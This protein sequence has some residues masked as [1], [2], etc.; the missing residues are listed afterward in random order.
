[1]HLSYCTTSSVMRR[2][3]LKYC[4]LVSDP[5]DLHTID[6]I[7]VFL[8]WLTSFF[9]NKSLLCVVFFCL[10]RAILAA[11]GGSQARG[12]IGAVVAGLCHS[13]SN[14]GSEPRL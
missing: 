5:A 2:P 6:S 13:H 9:Y 4:L 10:F 7:F 3:L 8:Q 12:L 11:Y 14:K 1:M